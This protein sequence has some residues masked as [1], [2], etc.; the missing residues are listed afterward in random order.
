MDKDKR[1]RFS[2][3]YLLAAIL[4][5]VST[6]VFAKSI[7]VMGPLWLS[8]EKEWAQFQ[9]DLNTIKSSGVS[10]ISIDVWW[11]AV[12]KSGDQQFDWS[13]YDRVFT[14]I[15]ETGLNI[16]PIM[17]FHQCGDNVEG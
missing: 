9:E 3:Y 11:G 8:S 2:S 15:T 6:N 5:V 17:S 13:Y 10:A 14:L 12:E 16:V 7:N 4:L 1:M